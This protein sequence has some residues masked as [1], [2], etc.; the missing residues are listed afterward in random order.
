MK[1]K[2]RRKSSRNSLAANLRA[3][4][5]LFRWSQEHLGVQCGLKRTY[6][7]AL[8]RQELNPGIDNLDKVAHGIGVLAHVLLLAP[9]LA[10]PELYAAYSLSPGYEH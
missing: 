2:T 5:S 7:G 10:Y 4:R 9:E 6:I 3:V 1:R 8:E